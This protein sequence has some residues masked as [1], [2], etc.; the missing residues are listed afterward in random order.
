VRSLMP[1]VFSRLFTTKS[2]VC[3]AGRR[4]V[5][6]RDCGQRGEIIPL[7]QGDHDWSV[8]ERGRHRPFYRDDYAVGRV[9]AYGHRVAGFRFR[10]RE[11]IV[12]LSR[13][14]D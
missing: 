11:R 2:L 12:I 10:D 4:T 5:D 1:L 9:F 14:P 13:Y 7:Y 3:S 8:G 6:L